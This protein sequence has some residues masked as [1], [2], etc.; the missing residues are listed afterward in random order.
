MNNVPSLSIIFMVIDILCGVL[1]PLLMLLIFHKKFKAS[2]AVF[3]IAFAGFFLF[4]SILEGG[5]NSIIYYGDTGVYIVSNPWL[6]GLIG[7]LMAAVFE[8]GGRYIIMRFIL[9]KYM[10]N[11]KN[12]LMYGAGHAGCEVMLVLFFSIISY[13]A[14]AILI[15]TGIYSSI[16]DNMTDSTLKTQLTHIA[17]VLSSTDPYNFLLSIWER[18]SAV[19][20][21]L[22]AS[23]LV[24]FSV[25]DKKHAFL[26]PLAILLHFLLDFITVVLAAKLN[27][28]YL[29]ETIIT[30]ASLL[31]VIPAVMVWKKYHKINEEEVKNFA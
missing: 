15:N 28:I 29:V 1:I 3:F 26:F 20:F 13:L 6:N 21:H 9:K 25:K 18:I 8:E 19:I 30:L 7:G 16:I 4:S 24:W 22:S 5:L 31:C 2:I 11:D 23:V 17:I 14:I 27:N 12:A 10:N